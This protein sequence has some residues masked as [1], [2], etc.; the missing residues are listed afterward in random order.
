MPTFI[1]EDC[2]FKLLFGLNYSIFIYFSKEWYIRNDQYPT[3]KYPAPAG[4]HWSRL[5]ECR[6]TRIPDPWAPSCEATTTWDGQASMFPWNRGPTYIVYS[7]HNHIIITWIQERPLPSPRLA[8]SHLWGWCH[9]TWSCSC[10]RGR[11]STT[12][13]Q[14]PWPQMRGPCP[15]WRRLRRRRCGVCGGRREARR[16]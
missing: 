7:T 3:C 11:P 10:P 15:R 16:V 6:D 8:H 9:R 14:M 2:C 13:R 1:L 5:S 4:N 12:G